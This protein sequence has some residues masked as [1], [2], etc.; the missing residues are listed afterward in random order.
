MYYDE[1][2]P[3]LPV[4][5][6]KIEVLTCHIESALEEASEE[7]KIT[8]KKVMEDSQYLLLRI[9]SPDFR[10]DEF[11][12][13]IELFEEYEKMYRELTE[14]EDDVWTDSDEEGGQEEEEEEDEEMEIPTRQLGA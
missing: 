9:E 10:C 6:L 12:N 5:K 4:M 8:L 13:V 7:K 2:R 14:D 11:E 3:H 1:G